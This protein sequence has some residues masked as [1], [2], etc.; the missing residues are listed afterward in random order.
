MYKEEKINLAKPTVIAQLMKPQTKRDI[1]RFDYSIEDEYH[2]G[3]N[4]ATCEGKFNGNKY[5]KIKRSKNFQPCTHNRAIATDLCELFD[6]NAHEATISFF[7]DN[8][9]VEWKVKMSYKY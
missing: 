7:L 2:A 5:F 1:C 8:M 9:E 6:A 4:S 3:S